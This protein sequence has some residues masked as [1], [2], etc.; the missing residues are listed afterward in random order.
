VVATTM[1]R[2]SLIAKLRAMSVTR[3]LTVQIAAL[4]DPISGTVHA[5]GERDRP[6][7]GWMEL[8]SELEAAVS[9]LRTRSVRTHSTRAGQTPGGRARRG[10]LNR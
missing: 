9:A 8:F 3:H 6:F 10:S 4:R 1:R 5:D 2:R 7:S